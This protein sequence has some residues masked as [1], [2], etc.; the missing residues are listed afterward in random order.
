MGVLLHTPSRQN[1]K[2][3]GKRVSLPATVCGRVRTALTRDAIG[4]VTCRSQFPSI[5]VRNAHRIQASANS[6]FGALSRIGKTVR[7]VVTSIAR[8][9]R[10]I[11]LAQTNDFA[12]SCDRRNLSVA[13]QGENRFEGHTRDASFGESAIV[14]IVR[15][16]CTF[17]TTE[18]INSA[19]DRFT[20]VSREA[21]VDVC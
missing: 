11:T 14:A 12:V 9:Y 1:P 19:S 6:I 5:A 10:R 20:C 15:A 16:L 18:T 2:S 21:A 8:S 4:T 3:S 13:L 17:S 7:I